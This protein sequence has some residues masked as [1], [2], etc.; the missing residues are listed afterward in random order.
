M[1][2]ET[3]SNII[4]V[5]KNIDNI[6]LMSGVYIPGCVHAL[7]ELG[8]K[9]DQYRGRHLSRVSKVVQHHG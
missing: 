5:P 8:E 2:R 4:I 3:H 1:T 7:G 9:T 6:I